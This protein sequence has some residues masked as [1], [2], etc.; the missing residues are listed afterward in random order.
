MT[1]WENEAGYMCRYG[2][3]RRISSM[4]LGGSNA[5]SMGWWWR[6]FPGKRPVT[7]TMMGFLARWTRRLSWKETAQVF[8]TSWENVY[9]SVEWF[10]EWGLAHRKLEGVS[11]LGIDEIHW[12]RPEKLLELIVWQGGSI[13]PSVPSDVAYEV[14]AGRQRTV[15]CPRTMN[16]HS[17]EWHQSREATVYLPA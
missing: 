11:S 13:R 10:V 8:Q 2:E 6:P 17:Q 9:R 16:P 1:G 5:P 12:L 4:P 3:F 15:R 7:Q 14:G